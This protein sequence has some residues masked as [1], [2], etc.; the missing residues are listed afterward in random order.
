[1]L[2]K[3]K[4]IHVFYFFV[5]SYILVNSYVLLFDRGMFYLYNMIPI[6]LLIVL[7]GIF[8]IEKIS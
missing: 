5:V 6:F 7:L 2:Q 8:D 3:I 4:N 1:M